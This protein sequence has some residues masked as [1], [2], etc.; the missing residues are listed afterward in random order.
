M[1]GDLP[2]FTVLVRCP[3]CMLPGLS[4]VYSLVLALAPCVVVACL[5]VS[6]MWGAGF[7]LFIIALLLS[8]VAWHTE[9]VQLIFVRCPINIYLLNN[10]SP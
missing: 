6:L 3:S 5:L 1:S 2:E 8:E 10:L 9:I 4:L 7:V